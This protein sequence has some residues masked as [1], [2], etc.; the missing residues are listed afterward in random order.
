MGT[1]QGR[2]SRRVGGG[3]RAGM[4][5]GPEGPKGFGVGFGRG[6]ISGRGVVE[7]LGPSDIKLQLSTLVVF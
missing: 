7:C 2:G 1:K 5:A 6:V 4:E 3:T